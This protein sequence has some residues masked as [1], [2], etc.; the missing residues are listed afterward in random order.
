MY[1]LCDRFQELNEE[2]K[3][4]WN[5]KAA[6]FMEAYKKE[7]EEYNKSAK[8]IPNKEQ[9]WSSVVDDVQVVLLN[10]LVGLICILICFSLS[11][12][13]RFVYIF[14]YF[15]LVFWM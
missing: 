4:S 12:K 7:M 3:Q 14:L 1:E 5:K 11:L 6:E 9:E 15:S 8:E 13:F 2:D 10:I